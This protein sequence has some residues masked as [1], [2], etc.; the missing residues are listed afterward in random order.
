MW[1]T[2]TFNVLA[3]RTVRKI[4][5]KHS[6]YAHASTIKNRLRFSLVIQSTELKVSFL[7]AD[8]E[9]GGCEDGD[10]EGG[11]WVRLQAD[12]RGWL[13]EGSESGSAVSCRS[14]FLPSPPPPS[15]ASSK[16]NNRSTRPEKTQRL[17]E[18]T[19]V[20]W[21]AAFR[22]FQVRAAANEVLATC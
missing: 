2:V 3:Y 4:K 9:D 18:K 15:P 17:P 19:E 21:T 1:L 8:A 6:L 20:R 22:R 11:K 12:W 5:C 7:C 10:C 13:K 14:S 16:K